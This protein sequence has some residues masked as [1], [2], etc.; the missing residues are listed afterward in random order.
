MLGGINEPRVPDA[1]ITPHANPGSY[2]YFNISGTAMR[3][4]ADAVATLEPDA[5]ANNAQA[6]T[7]VTAN[8]PGIL[9]KKIL[10]A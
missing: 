4:I 10:I 9:D 5:D 7:L 1:A 6:A 2:L 8:P 3:D